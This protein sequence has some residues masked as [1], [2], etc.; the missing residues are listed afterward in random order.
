MTLQSI[1]LANVKGD[2]RHEPLIEIWKTHF[3]HH[4]RMRADAILLSDR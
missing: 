2:K 3:C 1:E 4:T